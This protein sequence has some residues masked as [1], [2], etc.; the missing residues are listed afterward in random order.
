VPLVVA[1]CAAWLFPVGDGDRFADL[2]HDVAAFSLVAFFA[3]GLSWYACLAFESATSVCRE[4]ERKTLDGLLT[5]PV[6]RAAVLGAKW[7]GAILATRLGYLL[8]FLG[9]VNVAIGTLPVR[10]ALLLALTLSAQAVFLAGLGIWVSVRS[11]TTLRAQMTMA[12]LLLLF[13]GGP[14]FGFAMDTR[15]NQVLA[16]ARQGD[17]SVRR[18]SMARPRMVRALLYDVGANP[19]RTWAYLAGTFKGVSDRAFERRLDAAR[20]VT[21]ACVALAC[22]LAAAVLWLDA[23]RCFQAERNR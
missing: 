19:F 7:L 13:F 10:K 2:R 12:V 15:A 16:A 4:R 20:D 21:I 8:V 14:W 5:L 22:G 18:E 3:I 17:W 9:A 11:R 6:S 23:W 1:L